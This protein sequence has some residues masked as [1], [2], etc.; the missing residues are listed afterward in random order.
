MSPADGEVE[1]EVSVV[2]ATYNHE[3]FLEQSIAS[4]LAQ[5]TDRPFELIVSEDH[6]TDASREIALACASRDP[7][8]SVLLS[9]KNLRSNEVMSRGI[10]AARGRYV[11]LLDGDDYWTSST[12]LERC[13]THADPPVVAVP[14]PHEAAA[15]VGTV[16]EV[17][18]APGPL[19]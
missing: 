12:K 15:G 4:V 18:V 1:V 11:C 3:A 19:Y 13:L 14:A 16:T 8:V 9:P 6:S 7:R 10:A 2:L 17:L 5:E